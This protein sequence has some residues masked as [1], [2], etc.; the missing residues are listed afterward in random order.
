LHTTYSRDFPFKI[1]CLGLNF[2]RR[3]V[4]SNFLI[5][6]VNLFFREEPKP[7]LIDDISSSV[8]RHPNI[9]RR[10]RQK[11]M[12][13]TTKRRVGHINELKEV[14]LDE[15]TPESGSR[16]DSIGNFLGLMKNGKT[17]PMDLMRP[18]SWAMFG[19]SH[20]QIMHVS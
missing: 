9:L 16:R 13:K 11:K 2:S 17:F 20:F 7:K 15:W 3:E 1:F 14:V 19:R 8:M 6:P 4:N 5:F 12:T 18:T 10:Q